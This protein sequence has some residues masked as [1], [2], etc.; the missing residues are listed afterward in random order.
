MATRP[1]VTF[2]FI[3]YYEQFFNDA[4]KGILNQT[5]QD[6]EVLHYDKCNTG[7]KHPK[8]RNIKTEKNL[9]IGKI[10]NDAKCIAESDI[11]IVAYDDDISI[12][13]RAQRTYEG[14]QDGDVFYSSY[15]AM[16]ES[17]LIKFPYP[18]GEF[19]YDRHFFESNRAPSCTLAFQRNISID[20]REELSCYY[21]YA[22]ILDC[23][24]AGLKFV[25]S[26]DFLVKYRI[27]GGSGTYK[28][29][30]KRRSEVS[31]LKAIYGPDIRKDYIATKQICINLDITN[32]GKL[33]LSSTIGDSHGNG[34]D[35]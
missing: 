3:N 11:L 28:K 27:W 30:N 9:Y 22:F 35:R 23:Y 29:L 32:E 2:V 26:P 18:V 15:V 6:Y 17:G 14:L 16:N 8:F 21:D 31:L 10:L 20:F 7:F 24:S 1:K 19:D 33:T 4:V 25:Y 12:P 13:C 34:A 5:L